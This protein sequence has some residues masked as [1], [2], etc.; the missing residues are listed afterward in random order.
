[1]AFAA[2]PPS[3]LPRGV[4]LKATW[5]RSPETTH[6]ILRVIHEQ[7]EVERALEL[8]HEP[9]RVPDRLACANRIA[10]SGPR[11]PVPKT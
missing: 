7:H 1:M 2:V 3:V 8:H 4:L 6:R 9:A 11:G 10:S 5:G